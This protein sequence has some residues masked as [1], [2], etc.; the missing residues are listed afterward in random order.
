ML[1][2]SFLIGANTMAISKKH[3]SLELL[4]NPVDRV[5]Y[6]SE[7]IPIRLTFINNSENDVRLLNHFSPFPVFFSSRLMRD[8][9]S[10]IA[11]PGGGKIALHEGD[12]VY[13]VLSGNGSHTIE[14]D[15]AVLVSHP[16]DLKPGRYSVE[17]TYRNQYG[18]DCFQ[19]QINSNQI[20]LDIGAE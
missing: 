13:V 19:G 3:A 5:A 1:F 8:D 6:S 4:L 10:P 12:E 17:I 18:K 11:L 14:F 7:R 20:E 2:P 9:G 16:S 15:L